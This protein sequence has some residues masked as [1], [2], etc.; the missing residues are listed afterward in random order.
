MRLERQ[1]KE[2]DAAAE[3]QTAVAL[4]P[5]YPDPYLALASQAEAKG[6]LKGAALRLETLRKANA[7]V[8]HVDCRLS[9]LY[10][11]SG[12]WVK[13]LD[14]AREALRATPDCALAHAVMGMVESAADE[15]KQ[16]VQDLSIAHRASPANELISLS[17][18]EELAKAGDCD[19]ARA[20]SKTILGKADN[21]ARANY[22][23]G[24]VLAECRSPSKRDDRAALPYLRKAVELAP[25]Q[26][27]ANAELGMVLYRLNQPAEARKRLEFALSS[28]P[29]RAEAVRTLATI[30]AAQRNPQAPRI[31]RK[32]GEVEAAERQTRLARQRYLAGATDDPNTLRLAYAEGS[33]GNP[34]DALDLIKQ[35]LKKNPDNPEALKL[36]DR[37]LPHR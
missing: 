8:Q 1:G 30:Y 25:Q 9:E 11:K 28:A 15:P 4:D 20:L 16:A 23:A 14:T 2:A 7:R 19:A 34:D 21:A 6:D 3:W 29:P 33:Q 27:L 35:V 10:L 18:A 13:A 22:V 5:S 31:A 24:Y 17:L 32:A 12:R 26:P 37:L 36:L